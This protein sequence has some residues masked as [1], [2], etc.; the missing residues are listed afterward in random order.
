MPKLYSKK[1]LRVPI[2]TFKTRV[3]DESIGGD[4]PYRWQDLTTDEIFN[5]KKILFFS[6]PGA[7]TP[8]CT[9]EQCPAFEAKY[10][11]FKALGIDEVYCISMNDA[12]VMNKWAQDMGITKVKMLPDGS[13]EFTNGMDMTVWKNN[14][15]FGKRS[16]RY[17]ALV[18]DGVITHWYEEVGRRDD[19]E[20]DPYEAT[21]PQ[22]I[23]DSL[24][25]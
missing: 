6:L 21:V 10:D 13:G 22:T 19:Y 11:D 18:I 12:F 5:G 20:F 24:V 16:W 8:T 15:G 25:G 3:R 2:M 1:G 7:F 9:D 17:A 23:Y 4:N 14:L